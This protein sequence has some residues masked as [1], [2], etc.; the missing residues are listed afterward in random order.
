MRGP[1]QDSFQE[2]RRKQGPDGGLELVSWRRGDHC[3]APL[4]AQV[5]YWKR[6]GLA[7]QAASVSYYTFPAPA[8]TD[9]IS[10]V[11]KTVLN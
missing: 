11:I 2:L 3:L 1:R 10:N 4:P 7:D 5:Q 8:V 6:E 9:F